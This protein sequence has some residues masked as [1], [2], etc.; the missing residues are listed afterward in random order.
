VNYTS[1]IRTTQCLD[2]PTFFVQ[3]AIDKHAHGVLAGEN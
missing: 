2:A 3:V 1:T